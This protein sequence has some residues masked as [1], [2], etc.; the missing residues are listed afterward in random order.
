MSSR[1]SVD[2]AVGEVGPVD[3]VPRG[4]L[5]QRVVD[6]G[7]VLDVVDLVAASRHARLTRSNA[8]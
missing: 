2:L 4:P 5:E 7:D 8:R 1:N 3:A 6:V